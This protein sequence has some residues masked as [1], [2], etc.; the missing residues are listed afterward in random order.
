MDA[1][2]EGIDDDVFSPRDKAVL[3]LCDEMTFTNPRGYMDEALHAE[4][5]A[6]FDDAEIFEL[7]MTMAVL[8]GMAKFLFCF[9]LVTR[10]DSCPVPRPA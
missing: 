10:E 7:G 5:A 4:L 3:K 8:C 2:P 9:D 6:H 1:L